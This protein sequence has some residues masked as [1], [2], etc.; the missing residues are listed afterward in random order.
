MPGTVE[1]VTTTHGKSLTVERWGNG[2]LVYLVHGWGSW[3]GQMG[4]FVDPL[5]EAGLGVIAFDSLGH[6][7]SDQGERPG[8]SNGGE[9]VESFVAVI[10]HYGDA[11]GVIA[12][13]LGCAS[14]CRT[15]LTT[16][17]TNAL[18]L[19]SPSPDMSDYGTIL[20]DMLG[21]SQR[22][23]PLLLQRVEE[24][25]HSRLSD[26]DIGAMCSDT[27]LPSALVIHDRND[28]ESPYSVSEKIDSLAPRVRLTST[29]GLG[30]QRILL[31]PDVVATA[32]GNVLPR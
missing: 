23:Q 29:E 26:F 6:G 25:A 12:H 28:K 17:S 18:S 8:F 19:V 4:A 27:R 24:L 2:P 5:V 14:A 15:L 11:Q 10:N 20:S 16:K 21:L 13:S 30:H 31:D 1:H 3:R 9:L 32:V 7:D 22:S